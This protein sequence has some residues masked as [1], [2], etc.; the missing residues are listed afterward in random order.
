M[1]HTAGDPQ[2][3]RPVPT[4]WVLG[5]AGQVL[6]VALLG[7]AFFLAP[8]LQGIN[9]EADQSSGANATSRAADAAAS[10]EA[11]RLIDGR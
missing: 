1:T 3:L 11:V 9:L 8:A 5:K 4:A 10:A 7:I 2:G 6:V